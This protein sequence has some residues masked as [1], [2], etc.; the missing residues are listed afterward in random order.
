VL[1]DNWIRSIAQSEEVD[2]SRSHDL[3]VNNEYETVTASES[4]HLCS[5]SS[6]SAQSSV[7]VLN[8]THH[9]RHLI[10]GP[11]TGVVLHEKELG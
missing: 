3:L 7:E 5:L 1:F 8:S 9:A 10:T 11:I 6:Y 4:H 2:K